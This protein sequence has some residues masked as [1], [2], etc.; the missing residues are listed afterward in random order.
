M[1]RP[2]RIVG[3]CATL[4][5]YM[6]THKSTSARVADLVGVVLNTQ[7]RLD[8]AEEIGGRSAADAVEHAHRTVD[9]QL[10][11]GVCEVTGG[12]ERLDRTSSP[13]PSRG[14]C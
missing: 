8:I 14:D 1:E 7:S 4:R 10:S 12:A 6:A 5:T 11:L 3:F 9:V 13:P 2:C